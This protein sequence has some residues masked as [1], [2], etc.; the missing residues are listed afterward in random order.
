MYPRE[1]FR[2][3][4]NADL[5]VERVV[6]GLPIIAGPI[7]EKCRHFADNEAPNGRCVKITCDLAHQGEVWWTTPEID[8]ERDMPGDSPVSYTHLTLPTKA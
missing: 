2:Q 4:S 6:A 8:L 1:W 3:Y 7:P 5:S